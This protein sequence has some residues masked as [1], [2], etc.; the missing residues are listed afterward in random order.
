MYNIIVDIIKSFTKYRNLTKMPCLWLVPRQT[1][2]HAR[3]TA[4][5]ASWKVLCIKVFN[6]LFYTPA[7]TWRRHYN[8]LFSVWTSVCTYVIFVKG[9]IPRPL[10]EGGN[11]GFT[12][13]PVRPRVCINVRTEFSSKI[14]AE[15]VWCLVWILIRLSCSP[16]FLFSCSSYVYFLFS[17]DMI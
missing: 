3:R 4:H 5:S 9:F 7:F 16:C 1:S 15:L 14:R 13:R 17:W 6:F 11:I 10:G 2:I 8:F 12:P